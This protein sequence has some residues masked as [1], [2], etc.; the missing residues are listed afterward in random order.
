MSAPFLSVILPAYNEEKRIGLALSAAHEYFSRHRPDGVELLVVDDG[1]RDNTTGAALQFVG[2]IPDLKVLR[3]QQNRGKG[4]SVR[5]GVAEAKG[6]VIG[7]MDADYKT[8]VE[9]VE[10]ILPWLDKGYEVVIG[11]RGLQQ[12]RVEVPQPVYRQWGAYLFGAVMHA[13]IGLSDIVD[14]QCG[15]KFFTRKAASDIFSQQKI[16]GYMFDVEILCL[17]QRLGYRVKQVP[18][19]W[20]NDPDSR[21]QLIRGNVRNMKELLQIRASLNGMAQERME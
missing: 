5:R 14:T 19:R 8:P 10:K 4:Y 11:S 6:A 7:F 12:S 13:L 16:D 17:A 18:I 3:N 9:E 2:S 15:F 1:S 21:L 20:V